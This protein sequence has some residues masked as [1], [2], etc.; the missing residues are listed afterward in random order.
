MTVTD[1]KH[2]K[3]THEQA[4]A[5]MADVAQIHRT[6]REL[7]LKLGNIEVLG[8][9]QRKLFRLS[10]QFHDYELWLRFGNGRFPASE[11]WA[12]AYDVINAQTGSV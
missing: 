3:P 12:H 4:Q 5:I 7:N 1:R 10:R 8:P 9:A 6:M 2:L 11:A